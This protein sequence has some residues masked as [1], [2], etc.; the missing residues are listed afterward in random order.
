MTSL[1]CT[2]G[3]SG[4]FHVVEI[5]EECICLGAAVNFIPEAI[6]GPCHRCVTQHGLRPCFF[7]SVQTRNVAGPHMYSL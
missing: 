6:T 3:Y 2:G 4:P 1:R 7:R 5:Y